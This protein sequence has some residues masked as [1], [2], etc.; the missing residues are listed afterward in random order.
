MKYLTILFSLLLSTFLNA[1]EIDGTYIFE[2]EVTITQDY[3][4]AEEKYLNTYVD[5]SFTGEGSDYLIFETNDSMRFLYTKP[6]VYSHPA[7]G[8]YTL[9]DW[10][11]NEDTE[12]FRNR[13]IL[14]YTS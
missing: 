2:Y 13:L 4:Y 12:S 10:I 6:S 9:G 1:Q 3:D 8:T 14:R 7:Q 11:E 5:T